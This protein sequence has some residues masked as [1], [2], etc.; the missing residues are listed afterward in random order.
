M[1]TA[2]D[3]Y[4]IGKQKE[5]HIDKIT[6]ID[7]KRDRFICPECKEYVHIVDKGTFKYFAHGAKKK[8][9][10]DECTRRVD[11]VPTLSIY[12]RL[13]LPI[14]LRKN[15]NQ[16]Q[17]KIGFRFLP[18]NLIDSCIA[19]NVYIEVIG[20]S[21]QKQKYYINYE[22][23][24]DSHITYIDIDYLS[25]YNEITIK[26]SSKE[27]EKE[28]K[29]YWSSHVEMFGGS[30][31][32]LFS[33]GE[34]GGK[35]IHKGDNIETYKKYYWVSTSGYITRSFKGIN[36]KQVGKIKLYNLTYYVFEGSFDIDIADKV[37][38][39]NVY[40]YLY[41]NMKVFLL[42]KN[43]VISPIWPPCVKNEDGYLF[44]S[45]DRLFCVIDTSSSNPTVYTYQGNN[46]QPII[47]GAK[48]VNDTYLTNVFEFKVGSMVSVDRRLVSNGVYIKCNDIKQISEYSLIQ[49]DER[50]EYTALSEINV[51]ANGKI[52]VY[53]VDRFLNIYKRVYCNEEVVFEN[54]KHIESVWIVSNENL[55]KIFKINIDQSELKEINDEILMKACI[56]YK[57]SKKILI[58]SILIRDVNYVISNYPLLRSEFIKYK[59]KNEIPLGVA[60]MIR[61]ISYDKK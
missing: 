33:S 22:N 55:I 48:K 38:F 3:N 7:R 9:V 45:S 24:S 53:L 20:N 46:P 58:N 41:N 34:N 51:F 44:N 19:N 12:E 25:N 30:I 1:K 21:R 31:G 5:V 35:L 2:I 50:D 27:M 16:F 6:F 10:I 42:E 47:T 17:L 28:L 32:S 57:S 61:G 60:I 15:N 54:I 36:F 23:F 49:N 4:E 8:A 43:A 40:N 59:S 11:G 13:G 56:R 26:Y 37:N 18:S 39:R 29:P 52:E 14:Y